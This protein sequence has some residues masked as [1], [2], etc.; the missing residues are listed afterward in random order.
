MSWALHQ[1]VAM[2]GNSLADMGTTLG[3]TSLDGGLARLF[4][5]TL[6]GLLGTGICWALLLAAARWVVERLRGGD[7][8]GAREPA[9]DWG[10]GA[11]GFADAGQEREEPSF[12]RGRL[13]QDVAPAPAAAAAASVPGPEA[14]EP[15]LAGEAHL[16]ADHALPIHHVRL[17]RLPHPQ[18]LGAVKSARPEWT[19]AVVPTSLEEAGAVEVARVSVRHDSSAKTRDAARMVDYRISALPRVDA[20][21]QRRPNMLVY[22]AQERGLVPKASVAPL[23]RKA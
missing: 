10:A 1:A 15:S 6:L 16:P 19:G 14:Q 17:A 22:T 23:R 7:E 9:V 18:P 4:V 5:V 3:A 21:G 2:V 20:A 13:R 12:G 8:F 11:R